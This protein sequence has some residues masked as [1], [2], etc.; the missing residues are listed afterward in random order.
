MENNIKKEI[1]KIKSELYEKKEEIRDIE[2]LV[3]KEID[4]DLAPD[5]T[6]FSERELE[7]LLEE[8]ISFLNEYV[9]PLPDLMS[10]TSHRK[11]IGKPIVWI[12]KFLF[13]IAGAY[14]THIL[15]KQKIF[16]QKCT[17]SYR[18]L[19]LHQKKRRDKITRVEERITEC[20]IR[21]EIISKRM[22]EREKK[23]GAESR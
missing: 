11:I 18:I 17:D 22:E 14:F 3:D 9:D 12:K 8:H 2:T 6:G 5:I 4:R 16:N 1:M 19:R 23:T 15:E 13:K 21:L 7:S 10:I 20:E